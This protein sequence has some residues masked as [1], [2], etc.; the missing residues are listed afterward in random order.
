VCQLLDIIIL[1][2]KIYLDYFW[3]IKYQHIYI[4]IK[5]GREKE[6]EKE[7][8]IP[9]LAEWGGILA[10]PS[11]G[12]RGR[13]GRQPTWPASGETARGRRED[14][15]MGAGPH[16]RGRGRLT[17]LGGVMGGGEPVGVRPPVR[18]TAVLRRDPGSAT[19]EWWQGMGGGR[20]S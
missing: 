6:K 7:K 12:A 5:I 9:Q 14:G 10:Q 11:A 2:P 19:A 8:R 4:Y 18:S 16:A 15:A 3:C 13:I 20:G 1:C 17:A